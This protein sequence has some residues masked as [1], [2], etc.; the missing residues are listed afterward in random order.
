M[1]RKFFKKLVMTIP[2]NVSKYGFNKQVFE[3]FEF[4][5]QNNSYYYK[6]PIVSVKHNFLNQLATNLYKLLNKH[7]LGLQNV[8]AFLSFIKS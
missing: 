1:D 7:V 4:N 2:Y 5:P 6:D 3:Q 8:V